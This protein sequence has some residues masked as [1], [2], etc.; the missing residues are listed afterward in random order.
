MNSIFKIFWIIIFLSFGKNAI[1]QD[2]KTESLFY[3]KTYF[4]ISTLEV[5]DELKTNAFV[6]GFGLG[7]EFNLF[8]NFSFNT[9]L[10]YLK[11][12]SNVS[13]NIQS[14][15]LTNQ[16]I[17]VPLL[18]RVVDYDKDNL[19]LYVNTGAFFSYL[20]TSETEILDESLSIE[21]KNLGFISGIQFEAGVRHMFSNNL[22]V[23][24]GLIGQTDLFNDLKSSK[25]EYEL[26]D[27]YAFQLEVNFK[28]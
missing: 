26:K 1:G 13:N 11:V 9:G 22:H 27:L 25:T 3:G 16:Y 24:L 18:F 7:K 21:E 12:T 15:F 10:E 23:G 6:T 28:L 14:S 17:K 8:S 2:Q 4:G 5:E 19:Q 20:F